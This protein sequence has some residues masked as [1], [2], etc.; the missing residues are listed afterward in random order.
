MG[1]RAP[2]TLLAASGDDPGDPVVTIAVVAVLALA[3]GLVLGLLA[4]LV[5]GSGR[6]AAAG[7]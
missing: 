6:R 5:V 4:A 7:G 3:G 2:E 1:Q